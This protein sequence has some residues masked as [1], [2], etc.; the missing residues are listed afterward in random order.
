M[1][2]PVILYGKFLLP[3]EIFYMLGWPSMPLILC[4]RKLQKMRFIPRNNER[5]GQ[6][7]KLDNGTFRYKIRR[8]LA[9]FW[10][11]LYC[12]K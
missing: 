1:V 11:F 6:N 5:E 4:P 9:Y 7:M 2:T 8:I 3:A 12:L 10:A